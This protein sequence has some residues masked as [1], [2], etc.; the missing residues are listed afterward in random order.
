[1]SYQ[2]IIKFLESR[3]MMPDSPPSLDVM[4]Q[5]LEQLGAYEFSFFK[6]L[7]SDPSRVVVVSGTNGK[8]SVCAT[9][10]ALCLS[11]GERVGLYTS[12][13]LIDT[14]ERFR[15]N[16][17]DIDRDL[18][19]EAFVHVDERT[20]NLKLTHFEFLTLIAV[21]IFC[22]RYEVD[23]LI[24]EVGLGG[25]WDATNAI[26]HGICVITTIGYDHENL[27][28]NT[29]TE[30]A[31]NKFGIIAK[32]S[33]FLPKG[34][35]V[36][37]AKLPAELNGLISEVQHNT[38]SQWFEVEPFKYEPLAGSNPFAGRELPAVSQPLE[39]CEPEFYLSTKWG[40]AK[41]ALPGL[42]AAENTALALTVFS[43]LRPAVGG[44]AVGGPAVGRP[45]FDNSSQE[46]LPQGCFQQGYDPGKH[47]A[48]LPKI[49]WPG[50]MECIALNTEKSIYLSGDH[51]PQGIQSLIE[52]LK[53]YPRKHLHLLIGVGVDKNLSGI[54]DPLINLPETSI[55]LTETP[56]R[57]RKLSEYGKYLTQAQGAW[58]NLHHAFKETVLKLN[59]GEMFVV[60]GSLYLVGE[61]KKLCQK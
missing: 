27:L 16:G 59:A 58:A 41:L 55:Y 48:V 53:Y 52:L 2:E 21:W 35:T 28:G 6:N 18:F 39:V 9:L 61:I 42:R 49:R 15:L 30:I 51:N 3:G 34:A 44:P 47:L 38:Q 56:F 32:R 11:A 14:T 31:R 20:K 12:P 40:R 25:I 13:H 45:A 7:H 4:F 54:L 37:H 46:S 5:A 23:R 57:G 60:T 17:K 24:L 29:L 26:P 8:G 19:C 10:E 50:R 36:V 22:A 1:M 43:K 33:Q